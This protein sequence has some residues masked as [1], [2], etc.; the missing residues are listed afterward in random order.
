M[1]M[2]RSSIGKLLYD[3][4]GDV[5]VLDLIYVNPEFRGQGYG[6]KLLS[7]FIDSFGD[8]TISIAVSDEFGSDINKLVKWYEKFGFGKIMY[9]SRWYHNRMERE[10]V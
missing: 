9:N 8:K 1:K 10:P 2:I 4:L 6:D 5:V 7:Q 3:T